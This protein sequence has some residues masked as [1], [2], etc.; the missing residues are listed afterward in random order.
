M[1]VVEGEK[2]M[3][4]KSLH[5]FLR[6]DKFTRKNLRSVYCFDCPDTQNG[7]LHSVFRTNSH[8]YVLV[9][10]S[11]ECSRKEYW[12]GVNADETRRSDRPKLYFTK[13]P[14]FLYQLLAELGIDDCIREHVKVKLEHKF[15]S[16]DQ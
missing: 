5:S 1:T 12:V 13:N 3:A 7:K 11:T 15:G 9:S 2:N 14:V 4:I 6:T 16:L 10:M 8:L